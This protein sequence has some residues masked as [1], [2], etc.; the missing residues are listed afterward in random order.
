[1]PATHGGAGGRESRCATCAQPLAHDQRYCLGCGARRGHLPHP[2]AELLGA[3][4]EQGG[5]LLRARAEPAAAAAR[6]PA[7]PWQHWMPTPRVAAMA[8]LGML[9]FGVLMG[10][11][12]RPGIQDLAQRVLV[13]FS[14]PA[15]P[16]A[17]PPDAGAAAGASGA[18]AAASPDTTPAASPAADTAAPPASTGDSGPVGGPPVTDLSGLPPIKHV[19]LIVL[20]N[21]GYNQTFG[22]ASQDAYLSRT[23]PREGK[24]VQNYYAVASGQLANGV[25]LVSGQ[26]PTQQTAGNCPTYTDVAPYTVGEMGQVK[27]GG[28]VYPAPVKTLAGQLTAKHLTWTAYVEGMNQGP[29]DQPKSCRHPPLGGSDPDQSPRPGDPYVTWRNPF[30][31]FHSVLDQSACQQHDVDLSALAGDLQTERTTPSV[32]YVVPSPCHDG[33]DQ[34]C[35]PGAPAGLAA[36]DAFL[37]QVVPE[38]EQS[39]A[40]RDA[41]LIAITFDQAPQSGSDAD[42]SACCDN[43]T[44]PNLPPPPSGSSIS[45]T[46]ASGLG[47]PTTPTGGGGQVG[48]LFISH[49]VKPGTRDAVNYY[50]HYSLLATI[51]GIF[52]LPKLGYATD[53]ALPAFDASTFDAHP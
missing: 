21:H 16:P 48:I 22:P 3:I 11:V 6:E 44:Y 19:F 49:Y 53:P 32:A 1:M 5:V 34:P 47:N 7:R 4:L 46:P 43:P 9:G 15:R 13:A 45:T 36:A 14:P 2:V 50:D 20:A 42:S 33:S 24:L 18:S 41:G 29:A 25:A 39:A 28:C 38:I 26:G 8:V 12:A 23:L 52:G 40:Y 27:G 31:Y 51:E 35:A 37:Q 30:V 10:S 17:A